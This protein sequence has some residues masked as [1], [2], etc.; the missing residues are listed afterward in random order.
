MA[1]RVSIEWEP[2]WAQDIMLSDD[3][4]A[5]LGDAAARAATAAGT[6]EDYA[7]GT[8]E[9][10]PRNRG[11]GW[12]TTKTVRAMRREASRHTLLR[13]LGSVKI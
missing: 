2:G 1:K 11:R 10:T 4:M 6:D 9:D 5:I 7:H 3:V 12:V 8:D 13:A